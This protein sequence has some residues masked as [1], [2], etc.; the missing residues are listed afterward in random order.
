MAG[1]NLPFPPYKTTFVDQ[2]GLMTSAWQ[3]WFQQMYIRIG[4]SLAVPNVSATQQT[5]SLFGAYVGLT[6][7]TIYTSPAG[8]STVLDIFTATNTD[9]AAQTLNVYL[10][11]V[12]GTPINPPA[13]N[14][15]LSVSALSIGSGQTVTLSAPQGQVIGGG[16]FI[17]ASASKASSIAIAISGRVVS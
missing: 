1:V 5:Q 13:L 4:Q 14:A 9:S 3:Q 10:V 12:G 2:N 8:L 15:N 16:G 6:N 11:P 7:A 17:V